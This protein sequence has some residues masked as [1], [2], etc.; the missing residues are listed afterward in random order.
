MLFRHRMQYLSA[1]TSVT[2][3]A[4]QI[5]NAVRVE[6]GGADLLEL[7][8]IREHSLRK[9]IRIA[10]EARAADVETRKIDEC[11]RQPIVAVIGYTNAGKTTLIKRF[12]IFTIL[13][14]ATKKYSDV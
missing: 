11:D 6:R 13:L 3:S 8:R 5:E 9:K 10:I 7:L 2:S 4:L 14:K 1:N 12:V